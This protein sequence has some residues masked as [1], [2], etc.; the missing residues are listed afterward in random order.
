MIVHLGQADFKTMAWANGKG[1]TVEMLR[2][3]QGGRLVLRL[4]RAMVVEEGDF[5]LFSGIERNLT[6]LSGPGFDLEGEGLHLQA[7][8]LQPLA[9]PGDVSLRAVRVTAPSEDFNVMSDRSLPRPKVWVQ[10]SGAVPGGAAVLALEAGRIGALQVARH[11]LVLCD[12]PLEHDRPVI[13]VLPQGQ[14]AGAP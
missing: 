14:E 11:D 9:F 5:S 3:E 12:A 13:I 8:P 10:H 4:S 1:V 2:R 6:V 7:R